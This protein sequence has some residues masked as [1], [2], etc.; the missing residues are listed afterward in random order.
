MRELLRGAWR[1]AVPEPGDRHGPLPPLLL[2][3]TVLSG[4]ID[5]VS[6]L[7]LG[8]V[9][10]ANMTGNVVFLG[11]ALAG[12]PGFSVTTSLVALLAFVAGAF[13]GGRLLAPVTHRG[14]ALL[15][16]VLVETVLLGAAALL[17][18]LFPVSPGSTDSSRDLA[19]A[20]LA[21]A[22]G[23]QN[24]MVAVVAV[25]DLTT[26]VV[27]RTITAA[28]ADTGRTGRL[29]QRAG[30][31]LLSVLTLAAGALVGATLV[32]H[33]SQGAALG[34]P[35]AL[36]LVAGLAAVRPARADAPWTARDRGRA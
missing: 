26:T 35:A 2:A 36:A 25:P 28:F 14:R 5:A 24:A 4:M 33:A 31:R 3:L 16:A 8:Q 34:V 12:A 9:F 30:R 11:F 21:L 18:A 23:V 6:Y 32:L 10:V 29:E 17:V 19:T 20:V 7:M 22:M 15:H 27:T 1:T 13:L